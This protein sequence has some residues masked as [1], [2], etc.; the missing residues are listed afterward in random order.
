MEI[1]ISLIEIYQDQPT[2]SLQKQ[3]VANWTSSSGLIWSAVPLLQRRADLH[4]ISIRVGLYNEVNT[5]HIPNLQLQ[6]LLHFG[7]KIIH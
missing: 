2:R 3:T 7:R 4:G 6:N 5:G 1:S